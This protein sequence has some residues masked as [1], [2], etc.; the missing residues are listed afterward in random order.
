MKRKQ[1][2]ITPDQMIELIIVASLAPFFLLGVAT[3]LQGGLL[4]GLGRASLA[5]LTLFFGYRFLK[6]EIH[7][8]FQ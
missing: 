3:M 2:W 8:R 7:R 6:D 1:E 5:S 4:A